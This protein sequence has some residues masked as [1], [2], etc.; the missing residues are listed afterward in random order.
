MNV[1]GQVN[2]EVLELMDAQAKELS[3]ARATIES[4]RKLREAS[5]TFL[6]IRGLGGTGF[7]GWKERMKSAMLMGRDMYAS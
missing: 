5:G 2:R 1:L 4:E 7:W 3:E 6:T